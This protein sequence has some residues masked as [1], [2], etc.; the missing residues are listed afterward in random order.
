MQKNTPPLRGGLIINKQAGVSSHDV[1]YGV[2]R[3]IDNKDVKVG[4]SGTLDPFATGV[5][6]VL[7]GNAT[8]LQDE[9][10]LLPKTY[11]AEI[12]LGAISDTDD[13]TGSIQDMHIARI[14]SQEDI[15]EALQAI[16]NQ[17]TQIPPQYSA[18]KRAGK[19]MYT[20][21]RKGEIVELQPRPISIFDISLLSYSYPILNISVHCSTG[22]YI[23]SIA[24]DIGSTLQV[25]GYC[26]QLCRTAIGPFEV[27]NSI[28]VEQLPE[29][30]EGALVTPEQLTQHLP[31]VVFTVE[32]VAKLKNGREVEVAE[33]VPVNTPVAL[34]TNSN[35]LF[36][37]GLRQQNSSL[38][39][40]QK[41]FLSL[42]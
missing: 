17:T 37:I 41:I 26:S 19:P 18:I 35:Q 31:S 24:R 5:L 6:L 27:K 12:T 39:T 22:T 33:K 2:R 23:R 13:L 30:I 7:I 10:H 14:P 1:I 42:A 36:G 25:G 15:K 40:P 32:N 8:R 4:H 9:L 38:L 34:Y 21:A 29:N 3:Y 28:A 16:K 11:E 20:H